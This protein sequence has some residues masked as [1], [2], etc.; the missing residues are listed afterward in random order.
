MIIKVLGSG[1]ASCKKLEANTK[2]AVEELGIDATIEKVEDFKK[3][4]AY[5]VM[6]TPALVVDEK[7]KIM[8]RVPTTEEIK[9]YL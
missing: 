1:C 8:G 2:Q 5:G 3:I 9:K 7:V 4:M 6:K